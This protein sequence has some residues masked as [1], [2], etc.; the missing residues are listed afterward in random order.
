MSENNSPESE[1]QKQ[2]TP[3]DGM[4]LAAHPPLS[5]DAFMAQS[6]LSPFVC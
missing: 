4:P 1:P 5:L 2:K 3:M 6:G